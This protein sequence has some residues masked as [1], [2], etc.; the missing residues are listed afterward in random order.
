MTLC[1]KVTSTTTKYATITS[2][3][4]CCIFGP[5]SE[6]I[7]YQYFYFV[8]VTSVELNRYS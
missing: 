6:F 7:I 3:Y 5:E 8:G 4:Y 1:A 2:V